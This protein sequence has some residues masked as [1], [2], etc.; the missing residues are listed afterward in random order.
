MKRRKTS[1]IKAGCTLEERHDWV[2][3]E[4]LNGHIWTCVYHYH[5]TKG[6]LVGDE[7]PNDSWPKSNHRSK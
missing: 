6:V 5:R 2:C 4:I 1:R 7:P 3:M